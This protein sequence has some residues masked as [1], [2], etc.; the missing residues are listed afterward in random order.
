[1]RSGFYIVRKRS[2]EAGLKLEEAVDEAVCF[3]WIDSKLKSL[4]AINSF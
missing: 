4:N 1:M 2:K 3:G